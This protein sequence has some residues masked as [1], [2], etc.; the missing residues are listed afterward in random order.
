MSSAA[1]SQR[2]REN[3]MKYRKRIAEKSDILC[4]QE[5][6]GKIEHL[7]DVLY[8]PRSG[9]LNEIWY[10]HTWEREFWWLCYLG[11]EWHLRAW[12]YGR[13]WRNSSR[14][15]SFRENS[16]TGLPLHGRQHAVPTSRH[17]AGTPPTSSCR[18]QHRGELTLMVW[19]SSMATSVYVIQ[20][21]AG[22]I[23]VTRPSA[24]AILAASPPSSPPSPALLKL[25]SRFS[26]VKSCGVTTPPTR[27]P[28]LIACSSISRWLSCVVSK[29]IPTRLGPMVINRLPAI[30]SPFGSSSS[31]LAGSNRTTL[32]SGD[33][34]R[35]I[36]CSS[37]P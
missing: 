12:C 8:C 29:A 3:T 17:L 10:L 33:G 20:P 22:S 26:L 25:L 13:A 30:T 24:M 11:S 15:W 36:L 23:L 6:H 16:A 31:D 19:V 2:P 37:A 1:S 4:H 28:A 7:V 5:T 18:E 14:T 21:R 35:S 34:L 32:S 27:Y 9:Y